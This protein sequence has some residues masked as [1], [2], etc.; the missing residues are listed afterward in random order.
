MAMSANAKTTVKMLALAVSMLGFALFIMP[1]LYDAFCEITGLNG[2][3][4]GRYEAVPAAV[5]TERTVKVQFVASNNE[6]MP[7]E[8]TP[9][10]VE[11]K[12]HP[13]EAVDTVF[14]AYNPT[15]RDMVGQAIPSLVPFKAASYFH[16]TECFCFNQQ[17]LAAGES[18]ELGLRFIVDP[19]LPPGVNTITLSYTLFDVT[20]RIAKQTDN[21]KTDASPIERDSEREG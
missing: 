8:F 18:A 9:G 16:K 11:M 10:V 13:G 12:V 19:D 4:G 2:K 7:W 17:T 21:K 6:N 15:E 1:P 20:E 14:L 5:D 3:T